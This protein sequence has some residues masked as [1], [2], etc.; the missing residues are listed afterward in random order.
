ML[1]LAEVTSVN[2]WRGTTFTHIKDPT[3]DRRSML[4]VERALLQE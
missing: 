4:F 3:G 2:P 1:F